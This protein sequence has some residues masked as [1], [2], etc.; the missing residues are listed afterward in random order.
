MFVHLTNTLL[1]SIVSRK[2][3]NYTNVF[4][5]RGVWLVVDFPLPSIRALRIEG[6]LEF[7]QVIFRNIT[8]IS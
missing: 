5:P 1:L 3:E 2:P 4:I 8:L 6:V 7:Q